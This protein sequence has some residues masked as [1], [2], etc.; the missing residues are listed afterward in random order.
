MIHFKKPR[1]IGS[2]NEIFP[3]EGGAGSVRSD[4]ERQGAV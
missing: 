1:G 3:L 4:D 2:T